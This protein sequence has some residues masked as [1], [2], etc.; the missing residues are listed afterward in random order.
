MLPIFLSYLKWAVAVATPCCYESWGSSFMGISPWSVQLFA[1]P[2]LHKTTRISAPFGLANALKLSITS[3]LQF[4]SQVPISTGSILLLWAGVCAHHRTGVEGRGQLYGVGSRLK[5]S[6]SSLLEKSLYPLKP[7]CL[8]RMLHSC[9]TYPSCW[10]GRLRCG[11][12]FPGWN[13]SFI[14]TVRWCHCSHLA[15]HEAIWPCGGS[16]DREET[17]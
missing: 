9:P 17:R 2:K 1:F 6:P 3:V 5:L 10:V 4:P 12:G 14:W 13:T 8:S 7:S 15:D 11:C 16:H